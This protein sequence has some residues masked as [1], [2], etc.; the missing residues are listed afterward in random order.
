MDRRTATQRWLA[1]RW[2]TTW[3]YKPAN[4]ALA[5]ALAVIC[6]G[7]GNSPT[8]PSPS[9]PAAP[10]VTPPP[11]PP[12]LPPSWPAVL[13]PA[14]IYEA[15][16]RYPFSDSATRFVLYDTGR[17]S[18]QFWTPTRFSAYPGSYSET[19]DVI[20]LRFDANAPWWAA[21]GRIGDEL[22]EVKYNVTMNLDDFVDG[23]Y[24]R[25]R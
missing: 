13:E 12:P 3:R 20:E 17:F 6:G 14:R 1:A 25:V 24:L 22:L 23:R 4:A 15:D 21:T 10:V 18:L 19:G 2:P 11:S 8:S 16:F 5:L 7:C 9:A